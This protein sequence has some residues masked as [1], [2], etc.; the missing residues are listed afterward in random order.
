LTYSSLRS[1]VEDL[2]VKHLKAGNRFLVDFDDLLEKL[3]SK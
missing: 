1:F 3:I 2:G